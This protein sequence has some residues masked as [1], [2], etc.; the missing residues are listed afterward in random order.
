MF[1]VVSRNRRGG[2][3]K[4]SAERKKADARGDTPVCTHCRNINK[5]RGPAR[6]LDTAHWV[7]VDA[8]EGSACACPVLAQTQC[9][10]CLCLGHT[11]SMC[12]VLQTKAL[13]TQSKKTTAAQRSAQR[14][15]LATATLLTILDLPLTTSSHLTPP[16]RSGR[17]A[18]PM[19]RAR[20]S[21]AEFSTPIKTYAPL[22]APPA[23]RK[24]INWADES[25]SDDDLEAFVPEMF[26][27]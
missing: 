16:Q 19:R 21:S 25:D 18:P 14:S 8:A 10:T 3:K 17:G 20:L 9:P 4:A 15:A 13:A 11:K 2:N 24:I 23:P 1:T 27:A 22:C 26:V 12:P 6:Q 7:R 5:F